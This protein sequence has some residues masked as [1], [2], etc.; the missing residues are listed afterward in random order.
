MDTPKT[1]RRRRKQQPVKVKPKPIHYRVAK[2]YIENG[3]HKGKALRDE[4]YS[5]SVIDN[6]SKVFELVGFKQVM[7]E[8]GLT[9]KFLV[10]ALVHDIENKENRF[11]EL[12]LGFKLKGHLKDNV[13]ESKTLVLVVSG[14]SA[15][16]Y[17]VDPVKDILKDT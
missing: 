10:S 7:D 12:Q 17:K 14:E 11:N 13:L 8:L 2:R 16:R 6:P 5:Q 3:G 4:G 9:D 15:T 1:P